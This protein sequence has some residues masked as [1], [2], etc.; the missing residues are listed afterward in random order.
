MLASHYRKKRKRQA[1]SYKKRKRKTGF[2]KGYTRTAGFYG[3]YNKTTSGELKFHDID[4]DDALIAAGGTIA[5]DSI[6]TIPQGVTEIQRL[7]RKCVVKSINWRFAMVLP[8]ST[9]VTDSGDFVRVIMY[10]DKQTNGAAAVALDILETNDFQS[11]RNLANVGRFTI[12]M[13]REYELSSRSGAGN[14][15]ANDYG[16]D[17]IIDSFFKKCNIPIEYDSTTGAI[18]EMRTNNIGVL[19]LSAGG[20]VNFDS[21]MR[22]RFVG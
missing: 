15:T 16:E 5:E 18:T 11:F 7:G 4:V 20:L 14:G 13:D 9:D 8:T 10:Q 3:R 22:V 17:R 12:L 1:R 19:L 21:K 6:L 2:R